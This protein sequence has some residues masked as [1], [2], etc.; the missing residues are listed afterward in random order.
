MRIHKCVNAIDSY[1]IELFNRKSQ[2]FAGQPSSLTS[3]R[4][5]IQNKKRLL[6]LKNLIGFLVVLEDAAFAARVT[7]IPLHELQKRAHSQ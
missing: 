7:K 4:T 1:N 5:P 6:K 3:G 2:G